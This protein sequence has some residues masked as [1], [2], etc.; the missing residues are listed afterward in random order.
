MK[1]I[2]GLLFFVIM[3]TACAGAV[4]ERGFFTEGKNTGMH[5]VTKT[6]YDEEG[7]DK[8]GFDKDGFDFNGYTRED[9]EKEGL[10][11]EY[12][13]AEDDIDSDEESE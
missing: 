7:Y 3:M 12:A 13:G 2:L 11:N 6:L 10:D 5:K 8:D 9:Y 4:D 1:K